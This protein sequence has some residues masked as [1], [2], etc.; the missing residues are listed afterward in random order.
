MEDLIRI[1]VEGGGGGVEK[2]CTRASLHSDSVEDL[3]RISV[4][5]GGGGGLR[6][7]ALEHPFIQTQRKM[8]S[9]QWTDN[10]VPSRA[11]L[12][13]VLVLFKPTMESTLHLNLSGEARLIYMGAPYPCHQG[14]KICNKHNRKKNKQKCVLL[15]N[16][17][18]SSVQCL[19]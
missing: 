5:G 8:D 11:K 2:H 14:I 4:G 7:T 19:L 6:S 3:I 10:S 12:F 13:L 9:G 17:K 15:L 18:K 16:N 1:S